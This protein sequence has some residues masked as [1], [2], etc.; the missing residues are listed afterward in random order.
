MFTH[1]TV[2]PALTMIGWVV[3]NREFAITIVHGFAQLGVCPD[4]PLPPDE[5]PELFDD[6][7]GR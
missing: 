5:P 6:V 2:V 1:V 4:E 7:E 3:P